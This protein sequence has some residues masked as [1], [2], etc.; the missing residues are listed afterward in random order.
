[1]EHNA[2]RCTP[3][4]YAAPRRIEELQRR[5]LYSIVVRRSVSY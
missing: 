2:E 1:M 3:M 4:W 5:A